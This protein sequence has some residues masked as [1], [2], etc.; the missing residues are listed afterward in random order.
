MKKDN[1]RPSWEFPLT[2]AF[3]SGLV[4]A[5]FLMVELP[6]KL[7]SLVGLALGVTAFYLLRWELGHWKFELERRKKK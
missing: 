4:F 2:L 3:C 5:L 7:L 1:H 6:L